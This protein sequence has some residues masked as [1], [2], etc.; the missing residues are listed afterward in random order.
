MLL[1]HKDAID[2]IVNDKSYVTPLT[3]S[4]IEDIHSLLIKDLGIERNI[5]KRRVGISG[6]KFVIAFLRF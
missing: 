1:N 5:R 3:I 6:R 4:G 2:F